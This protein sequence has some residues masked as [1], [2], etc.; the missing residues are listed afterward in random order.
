MKLPHPHLHREGVIALKFA[1]VGCLGFLADISVLHLCLHDLKLSPFAGRA[2]S[3]TCAMQITFLVNGLLVFRCLSLRQCLRQWA[4][5]MATNGVGNLINYL[6]FAGLVGSRWPEVSRTG[7]ALVIGSAIAYVFNF[8]C[9][10]LMVFGAPRAKIAAGSMAVPTIP[11]VC[12][13]AL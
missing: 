2:V 8:A 1:A 3:L 13:T 10:R 7:W 12:D 6:V 4:G 11:S 9:V 5:Y